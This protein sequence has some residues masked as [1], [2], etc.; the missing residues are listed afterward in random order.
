MALLARGGPEAAAAAL[1]RAAFRGAARGVLE[2]VRDGRAASLPLEPDARLYRDLDGQPAAI[3]ELSLAVGDTV[4]YVAHEGRVVFLEAAPEPA[5][6][7]AADRSSRYF[8][9]EVRATPE[10][11]SRNAPAGP[12]RRPARPGSAA[13]GGLGTRVVELAVVGRDAGQVLRGLRIR[14]ALGLRENLFVIDRERDAQGGVRRFI[15]TGKGWGHGVGLCQVGAFGMAQAGATFDADPQALLHRHPPRTRVLTRGL[16]LPGQTHLRA[17]ATMT[18]LPK[19]F[20][21]YAV[22]GGLRGQLADLPLP[23]IL[24][25]LR[26]SRSTGILSLVSGGARKDVYLR[27]GRVVFASCNLPNDRLGELLLREGKI[28]IEEYEASIRA[29]SKGKR[30]GKALLESG[31]LRPRDLWEGVQLQVREIAESVLGWD[32]GQFQFESSEAPDRERITVDLDAVELILA[33]IRRQDAEGRL[34]ARF[35]EGDVVLERARRG[36]AVAALGGARPPAGGRRAQRAG[37]LPGQRAGGQRDAEGPLSPA[38]RRPGPQQ[39][40]QGLHAGPGLRPRGDG[41]LR[42]GLLQQHVRPDLPVHGARRSAR[43]RST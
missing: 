9:W 18:A 1:A 27:D 19:R 2:V 30:Q 38:G 17:R 34:A 7:P 29:I 39:G 33:G 21:P 3:S 16:A 8:R 14:S 13:A 6:G 37:D 25:H 15:F 36:A 32:E 26:L 24:Q 20:E 28:T 41:P 43:S 35:P 11:L 5:T 10:E 12:H 22:P 4:E 42:A 23:D 40:P 31:A